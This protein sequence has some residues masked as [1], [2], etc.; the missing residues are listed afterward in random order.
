M[1]MR[2]S[3]S[4]GGALYRD[5]AGVGG[6]RLAAG[7]RR[8]AAGVAAASGVRGSL[9]ISVPPSEKDS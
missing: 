6:W 2:G 7:G 3:G 5:T 1:C 8:L 4:M 9:S